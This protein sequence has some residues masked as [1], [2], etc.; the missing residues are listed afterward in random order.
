MET[1]LCPYIR[2][3][4][5]NILQ[6]N[7][8]IAERVIFDYELL[9]I[10]EGKAIITLE[11]R[12]Y[13]GGKGDVFIFRPRQRHAIRMVFDEQLVQPH[14]HFDLTYHP[15]RAVVPISYRNMDAI[16]PEEMSY[17][18]EDILD[19]FIAPFPSHFH[20]HAPMYIEQMIFDI[21]HAFTN[22]GPYKEITL[23]HLFLRLWEQVLNELTYGLTDT[24]AHEDI[25]SR[26][27]FFIEQNLT[28]PLPLDEIARLTHF[29]R[30][31]VSRVFLDSF[32]T[33]PLRYHTLLRVQKAKSMIQ[34]TNMSMSEIATAV[35][36][37][38]LQDFSRVFKKTDGF[39]P[40]TYRHAARAGGEGETPLAKD[41]KID[42]SIK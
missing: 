34:F 19:Q 18:R 20:P 38:S 13:T 2:R 8:H 32:G 22:P 5:Y 42:D 40:S 12:R 25:S 21:I 24:R 15:D 27:K 14:I 31:Y 4:W 9:Y 17:F 3:A 36:F 23:T 10:K 26:I 16:K 7:E 1:P 6:P 33:S 28:R 35:G 39:S 30:S 37:E 41:Q 11:D 29:S